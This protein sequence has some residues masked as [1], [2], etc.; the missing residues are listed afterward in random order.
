MAVFLA[1]AVSASLSAYH[2][3]VTGLV[4][5]GRLHARDA[6]PPRGLPLLSP[7][8][9]DGQ[10][11]W[12]QAHDPLLL[13]RSTIERL[14]HAYPGYFLQ[15]PGY[16]ALAFLLSFGS[17]ALLPWAM[18]LINIACAVV[19]TVMVSSWAQRHGRS[20][21][22]GAVIGLMP[23]VIMSTQRDLSDLLAVTLMLAGMLSWRDGRRWLSAALLSGAVLTRE[24]M[25]LA[26]V[27]IGGASAVAA[28]RA[29]RDPAQRKAIVVASWPT[30]VVPALAFWGWQLYARTRVLGAGAGHAQISGGTVA[31]LSGYS[32][33]LHGIFVHPFTAASLWDLACVALMLVAS[34]LAVTLLRR[35]A[36]AEVL[37]AILFAASLVVI[38]FGDWWG[39][40]RYS[41]PLFAMVL[42]AGLEHRSRVALGICATVAVLGVAI[43]YV[44]PGV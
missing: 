35:G 5:F 28:L 4:T 24:P 12:I 11:Y 37:A 23:G 27:A 33:E 22:W 38:T 8:G 25:V 41:L 42:I 40:G 6:L 18:L 19:L 43:P 16:P 29:W 3:D 9:Y 15:R 31:S 26:V 20:P 39:E 36:R 13:A 2:G 34:I 7:D 1:L 10:L 44:V 30:V 21:W 17:T 32:A 14:A